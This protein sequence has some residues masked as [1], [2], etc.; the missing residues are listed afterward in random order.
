MPE[1]RPTQHLNP[2]S[3]LERSALVY[4][5]EHAVVY[6]DRAYSYSEFFERTQRL[7]AALRNA[8][9]EKG[10]RVAFLV[11]NIPA[12]LEADFGPLS[13]GAVLVALNIRLSAREI[14]YILN[15]SGS[16]I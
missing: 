10:D 3:F 14:A 16:K 2:L 9:V 6:N 11:P 13:I 15:H 1:L 4:P 7:G 8:G 12:M 5:H